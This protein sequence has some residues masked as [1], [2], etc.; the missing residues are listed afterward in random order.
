MRPVSVG[1]IG[2]AIGLLIAAVQAFV[3]R[4]DV[5]GWIWVFIPILVSALFLWFSGYFDRSKG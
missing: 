5:S 3:N 4:G 1:L 2:G